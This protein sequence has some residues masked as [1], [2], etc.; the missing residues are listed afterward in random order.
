MDLA[1]LSGWESYL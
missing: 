1:V